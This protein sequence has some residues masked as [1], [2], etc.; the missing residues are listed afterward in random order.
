MEEYIVYLF[1]L[2]VL[3]ILGIIITA[4]CQ[5]LKISNILFLVLAGYLLKT[6]GLDYFNNDI[7]LVLS[8]LALIIIVLETTMRVDLLH[9]VKNFINVLKFNIVYLIVSSYV[10]TL[11]IY[12]IFDFPGK[13]FEV[14]AL[15]LLLSLII[16]GVDPTISMEFFHDKKT[17]IKEMLEIEGFISGPIVVIFSFFIINYISEPLA[18]S[19]PSVFLSLWNIV[20]PIITALLIGVVMAYIFYKFT[21]HFNITKELNALLIISLGISVFVLGEF[22]GANG[23]IA[24]A[25]YGIFLRGLTKQRMPKETTSLI[26]HILFIIVFILFGV[27]F[28]F[29]ELGFWLKGISLFVFYLLLRF[30]CIMLFMKDLIWKEK[31]FMTLNVAKGIEVALVLFIM[32]LNFSNISGI[33]LI[34]GLGYMFFI[35]SYILSTLINHFNHY[36]IT[37]D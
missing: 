11:A 6:A 18:F 25:V 35:L 13:G 8:S 3:L 17:K 36:F 4:I 20:N 15:C 19:A 22:T 1:Y 23:S 28:F 32:K 16:Y 14:F 10:M 2:A 37:E 21:T 26:A 12:L 24:V 7:I 5:K 27:E 34:L 30:M 29:P 31:F 33:N 9:I